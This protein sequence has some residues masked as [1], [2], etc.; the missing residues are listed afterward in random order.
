MHGDFFSDAGSRSGLVN[1]GAEAAVLGGLLVPA[2]A[3]RVWRA[4]AGRLS[5]ADFGLAAHVQ[6]FAAAARRI[7]A[8]RPTDAA[9]FADLA[10]DLEPAFADE[11]GGAGAYLAEIAGVGAAA[12]DF[13]GYVEEVAELSRRRRLHA[14]ALAA[15]GAALNRGLPL[16]E[17]VSSL[18]ADAETLVDGGRG[19][20]RREV[21]A[22]LVNAVHR[23]APVDACG[24][25]SL[26][27]ALAGGLHRGRVYCV[28][29]LSKRGKTMFA[30]TIS[31]HLNKTGIKHAYVAL[32]MGSQEIEQRQAA[33]DLRVSSLALLGEVDQSLR[34]RLADYAVTAESNTHYID[35][36][37]GTIDELRSEVLAAV[38]RHCCRGIIID[39]WQLISGRGRGVTEEE[40][41]RLV[42][43]W[44]AAAAKRLKIWVLVLAQLADDGEATA[45]SRTGMNRAAD[46]LLFIRGDADAEQ[47][48]IEMRASRYTPVGDIGSRNV[49]AFKIIQPGPHICD[50]GNNNTY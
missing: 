50:L 15:A 25:P 49:P 28:A 2:T 48:W 39:Y 44:L 10:A 12:I 17:S 33:R 43:Q 1:E 46:M 36:P 38:H 18:L 8:G 40:H 11:P 6:I 19:K 27:R 13:R 9:L 23:P 20:A 3:A 37:G 41:L 34:R 29:G 47:R 7:E 14:A 35:L 22:S 32:E 21:L 4:C 30:T 5:A 26:D 31:H 24:L 16:V 42:A 45:V